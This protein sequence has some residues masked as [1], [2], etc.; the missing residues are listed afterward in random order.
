MLARR[1]LGLHDDD[2]IEFGD[3]TWALKIET[4]LRRNGQATTRVDADRIGGAAV[5]LVALAAA[6]IEVDY[7][8]R[9][10]ASLTGVARKGRS[11]SLPGNLRARR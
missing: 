4:A 3:E 10:A 11:C 1:W 7:L 5:A 9:L 8:K 6:T 2:V